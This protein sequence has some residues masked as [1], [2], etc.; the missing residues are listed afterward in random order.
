M[1]SYLNRHGMEVFG[2]YRV[3]LAIAVTAWLIWPK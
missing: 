2:W 1:V 3:L